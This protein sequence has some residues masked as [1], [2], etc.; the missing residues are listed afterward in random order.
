[1]NAVAQLLEYQ[2]RHKGGVVAVRRLP[3]DELVALLRIS[4]TTYREVAPHTR[5]YICGNDVAFI[6][7]PD[8]QPTVNQVYTTEIKNRDLIA[9]RDKN[10]ST[11]D[12]AVAYVYNWLRSRQLTE[13]RHRAGVI[14]CAE[15]SGAAAVD[16]VD[17]LLGVPNHNVIRLFYNDKYLAVIGD[18][19][20]GYT[21]SCYTWNGPNEGRSVLIDSLTRRNFL[22]F[23]HDDMDAAVH[24]AREWMQGLVGGHP[25]SGAG[26]C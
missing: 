19:P 11:H 3:H 15:F 14:T 25:W 2:P 22:G 8:R 20:G 4:F 24:M 21:V 5:G 16:E 23:D 10:F 18:N 7:A 17:R 26:C 9:T 1:M 6:Y 13:S 12:E